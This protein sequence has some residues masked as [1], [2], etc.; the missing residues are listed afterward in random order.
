MAFDATTLFGGA[1]IAAVIAMWGTIKDLWAR[2]ASLIVVTIELDNDLAEAMG[3]YAWSSG[4]FRRS[5]FGMRKFMGWSE[6]VRPRKRIE[7]VGFEFFSTQ[8]TVFWKGYRPLLIGWNEKEGHR[9]SLHVT[10]VRGFFQ[11]DA[12]IL[13]ALKYFNDSKSVRTRNGRRFKIQKLHGTG[14][15]TFDLASDRDRGH[16]D[17]GGSSPQVSANAEGRPIGLTYDELGLASDGASSLDRMALSG[18]VDAAVVEAQRWL[19]GKNW[20]EARHIPWRRGW[21]LHGKPGTGKT[22]LA[23]SVAQSLDLPI[24]VFDLGSMTNQEFQ[25]HWERACSENP[26]MVLI[27][28]LDGVFD[29]RTN[30]LGDNGGGLTFDTFLNALSGVQSAD[31]VFV[32]ITTNHLDKV[33]SALGQVKDG[34]STRPGRLDRVLELA[35]P[36]HE[37]RLKIAQRILD[38]YPDL[39]ARVVEEGTKD[40]GAQ[41][42][43]RCTS[44]A[45]ARYWADKQAPASKESGVPLAWR[46]GQSDVDAM[47]VQGKSVSCNHPDAGPET[48][49][50]SGELDD[51]EMLGGYSGARIDRIDNVTGSAFGLPS[52]T[53]DRY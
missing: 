28:D 2:V 26:C 8:S 7:V 21:L 19:A 43:E 24:K 44:L 12:L 23:R 29:G 46:C 32:V 52:Q 37:G 25:R 16:A 22:T 33:D 11:H 1:A 40:T 42:Q 14:R 27:E 38:A 53:E 50:A 34:M 18:E 3:L 17:A 51:P 49:G 41:F 45:L 6:Y 13:E 9:D 20:Y 31:G 30:V 15:V 39:I 36:D 48:N 10:F 5:P 4:K 35:N 47:S